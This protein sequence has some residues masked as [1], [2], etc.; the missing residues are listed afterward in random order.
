VPFCGLVVVC[1]VVDRPLCWQS[2]AVMAERRRPNTGTYAQKAT[3]TN[4]HTESRYST[5]MRADSAATQ[6]RARQR[7]WVGLTTCASAQPNPAAFYPPPRKRGCNYA[8][9][10]AR[11]TH[12]FVVLSLLALKITK[13]SVVTVPNTV[14]IRLHGTLGHFVAPVPAMHSRGM[15]GRGSLNSLPIAPISTNKSTSIGTPNRQIIAR[16]IVAKMYHVLRTPLGLG[17]QN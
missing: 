4:P 10:L 16:G 15:Q 14:N 7:C 2:T 13:S 11:T 17:Q 1:F 12:G 9:L 6:L 5:R 8:Y 3:S